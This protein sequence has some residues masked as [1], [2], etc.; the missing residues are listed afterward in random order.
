MHIKGLC[1][2][3]AWSSNLIYRTAWMHA[4]FASI[5]RTSK[6]KESTS[7]PLTARVQRVPNNLCHMQVSFSITAFLLILSG[8]CEKHIDARCTHTPRCRQKSATPS[9]QLARSLPYERMKLRLSECLQPRATP[10]AHLVMCDRRVSE[11]QVRQSL[12]KVLDPNEPAH[13]PPHDTNPM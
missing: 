6:L 5:L 8:C 4:H 3:P 2:L 12:D 1:I 10:I 7:L 11:Q 9:A 13:T